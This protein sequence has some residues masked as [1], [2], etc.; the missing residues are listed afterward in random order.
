MVVVGV[1]VRA[2]SGCGA[3]RPLLRLLLAMAVGSTPCGVTC[4][5][6]AG[7]GTRASVRSSV[8]VSVRA[9]G[10]RVGMEVVAVRV[11]AGL[12]C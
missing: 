4:N 12:R 3:R 5:P 10:A 1:A 7:G 2:G 9:R 8:R 11:A 6:R